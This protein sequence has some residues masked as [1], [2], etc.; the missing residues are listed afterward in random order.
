MGDSRALS[1]AHF[2]SK[3]HMPNKTSIGEKSDLL[4]VFYPIQIFTSPKIQGSPKDEGSMYYSLFFKKKS[5]Q[6]RHWHLRF[7][8]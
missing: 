8:L 4:F 5:D 2:P 1:W 7:L 3:L 6:V